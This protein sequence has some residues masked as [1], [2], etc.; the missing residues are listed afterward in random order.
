MKKRFACLLAGICTLASAELVVKNLPQSLER[1]L[2][3]NGLL[4]AE[5]DAQGVLHLR[6]KKATISEL[7]Y[8]NFVMHGLCSE[9]WRDPARFAAWNLGKVELLAVDGDHG[10]AHAAVGD[11]VAE[12]DVGELK[13]RGVHAET[14]AV[15]ERL[16]VFD[17]TNGRD[18]AGE[19]E[20]FE[21]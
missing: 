3:G 12:D 1:P 16:D 14:D 10:Q 11:A 17:A 18:D 19:H 2:Q 21:P 8:N 13:A 20:G 7:D 9:Q 4:A 15:C 5:M 6:S